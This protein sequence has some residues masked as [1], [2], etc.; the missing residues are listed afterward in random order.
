MGSVDS[1]RVS[2]D[3]TYSGYF[4]K[5]NAIFAY[6]TNTLCGPAFNSVLLIVFVLKEKSYN[7]AGKIPAVWAVPLSL[8]ATDGIDFSFFSSRYLDVSVP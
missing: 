3:P 2:R 7:P 5:Q 4:S 1:V 8:A 6:G